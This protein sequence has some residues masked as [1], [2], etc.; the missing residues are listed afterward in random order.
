MVSIVVYNSCGF[1]QEKQ[2][3]ILSA[4][5]ACQAV[6]TSSQFGAG[7]AIHTFAAKEQKKRRW[8]EIT[9]M[10]AAVLSVIFIVVCFKETIGIILVVSKMFFGFVTKQTLGKGS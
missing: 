5:G 3:R 7:G 6:G 1:K 2:L 9:A 8:L 10:V 4:E